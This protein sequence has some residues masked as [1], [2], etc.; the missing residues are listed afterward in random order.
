MRRSRRHNPIHVALVAASASVVTLSACIE[1]PLALDADVAPGASAPTLD[2]TILAS[3]LPSWRDTTYSG[4]SLASE[5]AFNIVANTPDVASRLLGLLN[6]PD[7]IRTFAD[8]LPVDRFDS[9]TVRV[10]VDTINSRFTTLPVTFRMMSLTRGFSLDSVSWSQ[11]GPGIPWTT[12]GGDLGVQLGSAVLA[13][14]SDSILFDIEVDQDSLMKAWQDSD[15]EPGFV[16]LTDGGESY[17][18]IRNVVFHYDALLEGREVPVSQNQPIT[19]NTFIT[20]PEMPPTGIDLRV[21]GTPASRFYLDFRLPATIE[22]VPLE[23]SIINHAEL[24]FSPREAPVPPYALERAIQTRDVRLLADPFVYG[25]KTPVGTASLQATTIGP[26]SLAAGRPLRVDLTNR[27]REAVGDDLSLIRIGVRGDPDG[28]ALGF[29][30][31]ASVEAVAALRP[32]L[33]IILT[34]P[35]D[36]QVPN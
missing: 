17:L 7:T 6:V 25:P 35:P 20:S 23:G 26:D 33:R 15:G 30:E 18:E 16:F 8:T 28:Q 27:V 34:P 4:F 5:A 14:V 32:R 21:G 10:V 24:V 9:V 3:D 31:F 12:P 11:A 13:E 22:G 2:F 29:W 36:F 19:A 1:D